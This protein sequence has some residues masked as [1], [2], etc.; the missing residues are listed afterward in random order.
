LTGSLV[1]LVDRLIVGWQ[2]WIPRPRLGR[3]Q[4]VRTHTTR[5]RIPPCGQHGPRRK[6]S[7]TNVLFP[8]SLI[9]LLGSPSNGIGR[10]RVSSARLVTAASAD[11][12]LRFRA[13]LSHGRGQSF[14]AIE[15]RRR[16]ACVPSRWLR[17]SQG[18]RLSNSGRRSCPNR[19]SC[20]SP[21]RLELETAS[22]M[23]SRQPLAAANCPVL[24]P[25]PE[26]QVDLLPA[27]TNTIR[28]TTC[29]TRRTASTVKLRNGRRGRLTR[30]NTRFLA[31][32]GQAPLCCTRSYV[33]VSGFI[34][35]A[36]VWRAASQ[37]SH[38]IQTSLQPPKDAHP[39]GCSP[40]LDV[41]RESGAFY[42]Y[43][44]DAQP[45]APTTLET[46]SATTRG[47]TTS[48]S[49]AASFSYRVTPR[50]S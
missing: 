4:M 9:R 10:L 34:S 1:L 39:A 41:L 47:G 25:A 11:V 40:R 21:K 24:I 28:W 6:Y 16:T 29:S 44:S 7:A 14:L 23:R 22:S 43:T 3:P 31:A 27:A 42:Y 33:G 45:L 12:Q 20:E 5:P 35:Q 37:P 46:S 48:L 38:P 15:T 13:R 32:L 8:A 26:H 2:A 50:R 30:L 18:R 17:G 49:G 19:R 36:Y